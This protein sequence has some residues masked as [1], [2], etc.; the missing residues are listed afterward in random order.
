MQCNKRAHQLDEPTIITT[1]N[2]GLSEKKNSN[3]NDNY[4][5]N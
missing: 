3:N 2:N 4:R 5:I 1:D